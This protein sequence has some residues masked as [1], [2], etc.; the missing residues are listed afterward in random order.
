MVGWEEW[1]WEE[2]VQAFPVLQELFLSQCKLKCLP[3]GLASQARALNKLSVR[4]VQGLIS[5]ENFSSLVELGLNED[6]DLE[7]IT[8]LPRLQKLTIEECPELKVLEGVPALQRLVLAEEDMESLPEYMGGINPRHLEL[9]CSLELLISIAA[10]QSGP[11]WDMFSHVEHVKAYA[12]EGDN[13]KK[14][15]VLYIAN[16][17]NLET[18]VSRSFMSRGT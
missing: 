4:Y 8:N 9:Y 17:F 11:E 10:G 18:N 3:P 16:P 7:R 13:R 6:L 14:W 5:L 15:Y 1:Q 12:R 2:Q